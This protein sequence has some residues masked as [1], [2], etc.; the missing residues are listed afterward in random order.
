LAIIANLG[1]MRMEGILVSNWKWNFILWQSRLILKKASMMKKTDKI[2]SK[3][4]MV[5]E[6][7]IADWKFCS[8]NLLTSSRLGKMDFF[9]NY[10]TKEKNN[11]QIC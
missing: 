1:I 4:P 11:T 10:Y 8:E 2:S 6:I 5:Y 7:S 3:S 9:Y